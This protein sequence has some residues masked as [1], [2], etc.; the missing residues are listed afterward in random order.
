M[1]THSWTL[2]QREAKSLEIL[3][4]ALERFGPTEIAIAFTGGKDSLVAIDL[5]RRAGNG[6]IASPVLHVDTT[7]DFPEIYEYRD[8]LAREWQFSLVI[9]VNEQALQA[10]PPTE[11]PKF[12]LFCTTRLKTEGLNQALEKYKWRA[13][14]TGV[15]WDEHQARAQE[16]YLSPRS[17]HLRVHPILHFREHDIWDYI[18]K[19]QLPYCSLYDRGYR[20]LGCLPC[21]KPLEDFSG[22]ERGG[23]GTDKEGM[24][25]RLR[26]LGYF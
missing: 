22:P 4:T 17:N 8:R 10:A 26:A 6:A 24:M 11:D 15:R 18:K 14:I 19:Y 16:R 5:L 23:R 2:E 21:T 12:C 13:L 3:Q 25:E 20:S 1:E 7:V 9:H